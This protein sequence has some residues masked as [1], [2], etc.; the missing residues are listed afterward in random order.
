MVA[1]SV[2]KV[3]SRDMALT[4]AGL[5][6]GGLTA[7]YQIKYDDSL[8]AADGRDRANALIAVCEADFTQMTNWFGGIALPYA[9]PYEVDIMP[10]GGWSAGWGDGPPITLVPGNGARI[11]LVRFPPVAHAT[12]TVVRGRGPGGA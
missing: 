1:F 9:I 8:S 11:D 2:E 7:H 5:T 3:G 12:G 6:N 10:G 4:T